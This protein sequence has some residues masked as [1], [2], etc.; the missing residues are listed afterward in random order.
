MWKFI[1]K[2]VGQMVVLFYIFLALLFLLLD[3]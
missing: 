3:L 1:L 2:R